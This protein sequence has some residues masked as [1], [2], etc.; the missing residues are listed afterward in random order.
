M[1]KLL[2]LTALVLFSGISFSQTLQKG[3][4]VGL[5]V[6][7]LILHPDVTYNQWK[8]FFTN[9]WLPVVEKA[10]KGDVEMYLVEGKRGEEENQIGVIFLFKSSEVRNKWFDEEDQIKESLREDFRGNFNELIEERA[11]LVKSFSSK[12]TDWIVQ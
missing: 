1:K 8:D 3:N 2:V 7:K 9:K 11:K 5:H 12:Y 10:Y 6:Q 4:L